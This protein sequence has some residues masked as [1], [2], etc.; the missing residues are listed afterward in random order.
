M[1]PDAYDAAMLRELRPEELANYLR[2][3]GWTEDGR[4]GPKAIIWR[5]WDALLGRERQIILPTD[6][7]MRDYAERVAELLGYLADLEERSQAEVLS[8]IRP[9]LSLLESYDSR[10]QVGL[11]FFA[12][13]ISVFGLAIY[14]LDSLSPKAVYELGSGGLLMAVMFLFDF[15]GWVI[16]FRLVFGEDGRDAASWSF[17]ILLGLLFA[18]TALVFERQF[19]TRVQRTVKTFIL[20]LIRIIAILISR[21]L[22]FM[23]IILLV[24]RVPIIQRMHSESVVAEAAVRFRQIERELPESSAQRA[25][26]LVRLQNWIEVLAVSSPAFHRPEVVMG[27]NGEQILWRYQERTHGLSDQLRV[28]SDLR[29]GRPASW[30]SWADKKTKER[31]TELIPLDRYF[32]KP[33]P[34]TINRTY[35]V[36]LL[37]VIILGMLPI[38]IR[39]LF[40]QELILYFKPES[41]AEVE[42]DSTRTRSGQPSGTTR[43]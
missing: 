43:L 29:E 33:D 21:Y 9:H 42:F 23:P 32:R 2:Q 24:L 30:P 15:T 6:T 4:L 31:I 13:L 16:L 25:K 14:G 3:S 1:R 41:H 28:L 7:A 19:L 5:R 37:M 35:W 8:D 10:S 38:L 40:S 20:S 26:E 27:M 36:S 11:R 18:G 39:V 17:S 12:S 22:I 34:E